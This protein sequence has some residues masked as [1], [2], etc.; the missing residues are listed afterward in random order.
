[1][2]PDDLK[3]VWRDQSSQTRL[4]VDP[5]VLVDEVRRYGRSFD[6][7]IFWRDAREVGVAL[8]MIPLWAYLGFQA[9]L[10]W[11]W[12]LMIPAFAWVAGYM[13]IDRVRQN[14][15]RS[16]PDEPLRPFVADLLTRVDHQI[17]LL[18]SVHLW[19]LLPLALAGMA[20]MVQSTW[21]ERTGGLF[22]VLAAFLAAVIFAAVFGF[23]YW[24]NLYAIRA[25]LE[26]RRRELEVL[27][28]SLDAEPPPEA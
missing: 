5:A 7:M 26:P 21:R 12:Y 8:I 3:Q 1:M 2:N 25:E 10:P 15:R 24:L 14:R 13:L 17:Q 23:V 22:M 6:A 27:L 20:F 9:A 19:Y 4:T 16:S 11:S 28:K 18:R